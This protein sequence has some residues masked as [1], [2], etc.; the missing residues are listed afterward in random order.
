MRERKRVDRL[1]VGR[2]IGSEGGVAMMKL[3]MP[4]SAG[5]CLFDR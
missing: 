3:Q 5:F 4:D 1:A 2:E